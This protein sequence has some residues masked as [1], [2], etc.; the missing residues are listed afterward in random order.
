MAINTY[1][2]V[3]PRGIA[4]PAD[5]VKPMGWIRQ[6]ITT[7]AQGATTALADWQDIIL[8]IIASQE[9]AISFSATP[10][11]LTTEFGV[12]LLHPNIIYNIIPTAA[13]FSAI[14]VLTD[15]LLTINKF[16]RWDTL[17]EPAQL[18]EGQ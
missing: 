12:L 16:A 17:A 2:L 5:V 14:A 1:P 8:S 18:A 15:G 3:D 6:D 10:V 13:Q 7:T 9:M 4:I 11:N